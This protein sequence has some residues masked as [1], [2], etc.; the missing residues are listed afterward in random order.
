[1]KPLIRLLK[2]LRR[3][4][5]LKLRA[6]VKKAPVDFKAAAKARR[7]REAVVAA[8]H[9]SIRANLPDKYLSSHARRMRALKAV[10]G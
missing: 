10:A 5:R 8:E 9:A 6:P 7:E 4:N 3:R 1:M 2:N